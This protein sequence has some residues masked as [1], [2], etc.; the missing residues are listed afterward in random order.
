M[1]KAT[2]SCESGTFSTATT[3][4]DGAMTLEPR[5]AD[6]PSPLDAL[7]AGLMVRCAISDDVERDRAIELASTQDLQTLVEA[8]DP[9]MFSALNALFDSYGDH[10]PENIVWLLDVGQAAMEASMELDKRRG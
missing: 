9:T 6:L 10:P 4:H 3:G 2:A 7:N 5:P 8:F 1:R